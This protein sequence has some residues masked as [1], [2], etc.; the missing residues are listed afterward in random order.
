M[1]DVNP[2]E[3]PQVASQGESRAASPLKLPAWGILVL[4]LLSLLTNVLALSQEYQREAKWPRYILIVILL[5]TWAS[6]MDIFRIAGSIAMLRMKNRRLVVATAI[7]ACVPYPGIAGG[8]LTAAFGL[9]A[10]MRLRRKE[11]WD[12]F[13]S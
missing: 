8:C 2:Y 6:L 12:A 7:L 3:A 4:S 1:N 13:Q 11:V 5:I 9:I 10:L